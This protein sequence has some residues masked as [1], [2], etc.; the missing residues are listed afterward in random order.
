MLPCER[1]INNQKLIYILHDHGPAPTI[2]FQ[3]V[4]CVINRLFNGHCFLEHR[5]HDII[6]KTNSTFLSVDRSPRQL[7][8]GKKS[9]SSLFIFFF[10]KAYLRVFGRVRQIRKTIS[11]IFRLRNGVVLPPEVACNTQHATRDSET[12]WLEWSGIRPEKPQRC[13]EKLPKTFISQCF[14]I[15]IQVLLDSKD[16]RIEN[17]FARGSHHRNLSVIYIVQNLFH[18]GKGS[19]SISLNSHYLVL[20][21]NPR[22]KLQILTLAKQMYPGQ[23]DFLTTTQGNCRLRTNV[24]PSEEGFNQAG[25]QENIPQELLKYLKQQTLSPVPLLP[26]MQEI[27]GNMDGVF[28]RNDLRDDEKAK[29][30]FQLQNRYLPFK[31]QLIKEQD[32]KK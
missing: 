29:R 11:T 23:T 24:L 9:E 12:P 27:Q 26:A 6:R 19:R 14:S 21:K 3:A 7:S 20:F 5:C 10:F 1:P 32:R 30:S 13:S 17:L 22:D 18:Q 4:I 31:E 15:P 28:S 2:D 8:K 16:K 25:F